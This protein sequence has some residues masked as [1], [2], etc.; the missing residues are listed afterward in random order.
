MHRLG[1]S[2]MRWTAIPPGLTGGEPPEPRQNFGF[3]FLGGGGGDRIYVFGGSS[4]VLGDA[5]AACGSRA[6]QGPPPSSAIARA[7][8]FTVII[9]Q[10]RER[11]LILP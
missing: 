4:S 8:V 10:K 2:D 7:R 3:A 9:E 1:L 5:E 6:A 11:H